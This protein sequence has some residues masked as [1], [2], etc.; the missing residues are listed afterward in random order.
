MVSGV[1]PVW[2]TALSWAVLATAF[3]CAG[4][5]LYEIYRRGYREPMRVMELVWPVTA[6]YFGP[7]A[8]VAYRAWSR[9]QT[10]RWQAQH[11]DPPNKPGYATTAIG[12]SHCGAGCTLGDIVAEF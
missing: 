11:G 10:R 9:P 2:L 7:A 3:V 6:L 5:I 1:V 12:V 8:V 4:W